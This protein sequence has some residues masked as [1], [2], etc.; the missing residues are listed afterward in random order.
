MHVDRT[1][2]QIALSMAFETHTASGLCYSEVVAF[3]GSATKGI[4][5]TV[6]VSMV[7]FLNGA[8]AS[9]NSVSKVSQQSCLH[10]VH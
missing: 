4:E 1:V 10:T 3:G 8:L 7:G 2:A 5:L 6:S 9:Q